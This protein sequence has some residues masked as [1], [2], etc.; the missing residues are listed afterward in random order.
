MRK[1]IFIGLTNLL[2]FSSIAFS[3]VPTPVINN[4]IRDNT[5]IRSREIELERVKRD[6]RKPNLTEDSSGR[7]IKYAEIKKDFESIQKLQNQIVKTYT[8][9]KKI[10]YEEIGKLSLE[11]NKSALRL[12]SNLF[13]TSNTEKTELKEEKKAE[14]KVLKSVRDLIVDLDNSIGSFAKSPMFQNLKIVD[15]TISEKTGN[16]LAQIIKLSAALNQA[17]DKMAK[18]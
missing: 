17:S 2:M 16:N 14:T 13:V 11:I 8:T 18:N 1:V 6:S 4:E 12:N 3:Q 9:G 5:S 10:R 7:T 15:P